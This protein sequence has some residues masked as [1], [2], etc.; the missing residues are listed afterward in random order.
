[1]KADWITRSP[2][3]SQAVKEICANMSP[4]EKSTGARHGALYGL[5]VVVTLAVPIVAAI[6]FRNIIATVVAV[7]LIVIHLA[8]IPAWQRYQKR[9]LCSTQWARENG[10]T[11]E[12]VKLFG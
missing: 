5:W 2:F 10:Y 12:S 11:P 7:C 9:F 3:Q 6:R 1:M 8:C 4:S